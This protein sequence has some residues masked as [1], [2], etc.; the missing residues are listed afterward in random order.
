MRGLKRIAAGTS[1]GL[2][3]LASLIASIALSGCASVLD[4]PMAAATGVACELVGGDGC[5]A[6]IAGTATTLHEGAGHGSSR[7]SAYRTAGGDHLIMTSSGGRW[8]IAGAQRPWTQASTRTAVVPVHRIATSAS[9][10]A[11]QAIRS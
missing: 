9:R 4:A 11:I 8:S 5:S 10:P 2:P 6:L 3:A 1:P 7:V